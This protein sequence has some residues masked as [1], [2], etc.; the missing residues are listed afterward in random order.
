MAIRAV[1][2]VNSINLPLVKMPARQGNY[3]HTDL[4]T[5]KI[6]A[7]HY[8]MYGISLVFYIFAELMKKG[9]SHIVRLP[10]V[11]LV[12]LALLGN[13]ASSARMECTMA[14][15]TGQAAEAAKNK[16]PE[17][18]IVKQAS[19]EA[20]IPFA[21]VCFTPH[22]YEFLTA[23]PVRVLVAENYKAPASLLS[24]PAFL[25]NIFSNIIATN[26]P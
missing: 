24:M 3:C 16:A 25:R 8:F 6:C 2:A 15:T 1:Q 5:Y 12:L 14:V 18:T 17:Q 4:V 7:I 26:A 10:L 9:F 22:F 19:F 21:H 11:L 23:V 20:V 13:A